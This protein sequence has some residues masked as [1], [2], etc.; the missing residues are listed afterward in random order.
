MSVDEIRDALAT[1][2]QVQRAR[3]YAAR[4]FDLHWAERAA[5][6]RD[7]SS[8]SDDDE[9]RSALAAIIDGDAALAAEKA[10]ADKAEARLADLKA[11]WLAQAEAMA[12]HVKENARLRALL[13]EA[14]VELKELGAVTVPKR[15]RA[16][17]EANDAGRAQVQHDAG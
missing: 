11:S 4:L 13:L 1:P 12:T 14:E 9:V 3:E 5:D 15:I 17:L 8:Y 7:G 2:E 10:R 16:A 6:L